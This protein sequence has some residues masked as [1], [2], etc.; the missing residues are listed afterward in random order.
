MSMGLGLGLW[1][2]SKPGG[3]AAGPTPIPQLGS[4]AYH[5]SADDITPQTDNTTFTGSWADNIGGL[6]ATAPATKEPKYRTAAGSTLGKPCIEFVGG[7]VLNIGL[8]AA[9][10]ALMDTH[11]F[12]VVVIHRPKSTGAASAACVFSNGTVSTDGILMTASA[13]RTGMYL[14][15]DR[16]VP[17]TVLDMK[18]HAYSVGG[19]YP[20]IGR[21]YVNGTSIGLTSTNITAANGGTTGINIGAVSNTGGNGYIGEVYEVLIYSI[22]LAYPDHLRAVK[23]AYDRYGSRAY[24][25]AGQP[26]FTLCLGD[27]QT[28]GTTATTETA[29]PYQMAQLLSKPLGTW[30][31]I[32]VPSSTWATGALVLGVTDADGISAVT[33]IPTWHCAFEWYNLQTN[34]TQQITNALAFAAARKSANPADKVILGTSFDNWQLST[35]SK[36]INRDAYDASLVS[37]SGVADYLVQLHTDATIGQQNTCTKVVGA[38]VADPRYNPYWADGV[39]LLGP[40]NAIVAGMFKDGIVAIGG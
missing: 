29:Y 25:W 40:G 16:A 37:N 14:A 12:T 24:P 27:S 30:G 34:N 13:G 11:I 35:D 21:C 19:T 10:K 23:W 6:T 4:L 17:D 15:S 32:G 36:Q 3:S 9:L 18:V 8:P 38:A 22:E 5:W 20:R 1:L 2:G 7:K 28:A 26:Y 39:H 33:G 31:N